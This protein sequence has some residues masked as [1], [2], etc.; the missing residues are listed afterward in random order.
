VPSIKKLGRGEFEGEYNMNRCG[1]V[2][3]KSPVGVPIFYESD[4][5]YF[6]WLR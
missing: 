4:M 5:E 6:V 1:L 2:Y 3:F